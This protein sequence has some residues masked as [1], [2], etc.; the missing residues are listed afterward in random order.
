MEKFYFASSN[1]EEKQSGPSSRTINFLLSYSK[2]LNV[3]E[4]NNFK[5]ETILN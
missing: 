1:R 4:C 5:F 2:S 3:M